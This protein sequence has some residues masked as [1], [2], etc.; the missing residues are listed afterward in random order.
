MNFYSIIWFS[1]TIKKLLLPFATHISSLDSVQSWRWVINFTLALLL[2]ICFICRVYNL[3]AGRVIVGGI[4]VVSCHVKID[5]KR[6]DRSR[7]DSWPNREVVR[8]TRLCWEE[9]CCDLSALWEKPKRWRP[10]EHVRGINTS[11]AN[12]HEIVSKSP[13]VQWIIL[14]SKLAESAGFTQLLDT[15]VYNLYLGRM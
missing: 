5:P 1:D 12:L 14:L 7:R 10:R 6:K 8:F 13:T 2:F 4:S 15:H 9:R 11:M 3:N